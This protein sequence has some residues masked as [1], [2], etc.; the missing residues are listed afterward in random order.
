MSQKNDILMPKLGLTMTE[1]LLAEWLVN[2][3]DTLNEGDVMFIVETDK[4]A[5]EVT[6]PSSGKVLEQVIAQGTTVPVGTVVA[7][8]TGVG[9]LPQQDLTSGDTTDL[10]PGE[11]ATAKAQDSGLRG[12]PTD[13]MGSTSERLLSTPLARK[14]ALELG[15]DLGRVV[16]SGPN[17]RIKAADVRSHLPSNAKVAEPK[18]DQRTEP[19]VDTTALIENSSGTTAPASGLVQTMARRMVSAKRDIPHFYLSTEAE[20]SDLLALREQLNADTNSPKATLNHFLIAAVVRALSACPWQNRV[21]HE[22]GILSFSSIDLGLAVT[23]QKGLVAPVV[24][25]LGALTFDQ[26]IRS[27][28]EL[29]AR[30]R[31]GKL[32]KDDFLGGA[33]TISNAGMFNVTYVTPIINPPQS[34][35]LGVGSVR[36]VFRPDQNEQPILRK[37][38]G[39][40]LSCDHRLHDGH[41]GLRFLNTVVDFLEHP[42]RLLRT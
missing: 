4:V 34:A 26:L 10:Q 3:G 42:L 32:T 41:S 28:S 31:D 21:W 8:W 33:M 35:I 19:F 16:G 25:N 17:G 30:V 2:V 15:V 24:K 14:L 22:D 1:G 11:S 29:V 40:V 13:L 27:S 38:I 7:R 37:E 6:A 12:R 36:E 5:T 20:I 9:Q 23:T 18:I 39:L